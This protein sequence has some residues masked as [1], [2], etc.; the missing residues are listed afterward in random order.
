MHPNAFVTQGRQD[1]PSA[2]GAHAEFASDL[3]ADA[4]GRGSEGWH[5]HLRGRSWGSGDF[6]GWSHSNLEWCRFMSIPFLVL[7]TADRQ[8][9]SNIAVFA[10]FLAK[11]TTCCFSAL[12]RLINSIGISISSIHSF[13]PAGPRCKSVCVVFPQQCQVRGLSPDKVRCS[14]RCGFRSGSCG[15]G[16]RAG[17]GSQCG[18]PGWLRF[19]SLTLFYCNFNCAF[20]VCFSIFSAQRAR[21]HTYIAVVQNQVAPLARVAVVSAFSNQLRCFR[22]HLGLF[23]SKPCW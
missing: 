12:Q 10:F 21:A 7:G 13:G 19:R 14:F 20:E 18:V 11:S 16:V 23:S 4:D 9:A 8:S 15:A 5:A 6:A 1:L 3:I 22:C 17:S 2:A